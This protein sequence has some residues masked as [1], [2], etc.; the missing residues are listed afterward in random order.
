MSKYREEQ[1]TFTHE[2]KKYSINKVLEQVEDKPI[3][4]VPVKEL[5]WILEYTNPDPIRVMNADVTTPILVHGLKGKLVAVDGTHRLKKALELELDWLP[6]RRVTDDE[7][8]KSEIRK[9]S[10]AL[11]NISKQIKKSSVM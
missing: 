7:L 1:S 4:K 8:E 3:V 11:V 10:A 2:G 9:L 5:S 6:A